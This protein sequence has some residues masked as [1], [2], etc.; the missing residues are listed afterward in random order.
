MLKAQPSHPHHEVV[1]DAFKLRVTALSHLWLSPS[2]P[3]SLCSYLLLFYSFIMAPLAPAVGDTITNGLEAY[4]IL[5]KLRSA[6]EST[7]Y[8][9]VC[10]S[11]R[12]RNRQLALK[13]VLIPSS[14]STSAKRHLMST[15]SL[16]QALH[17]P[18]IVS[19][20]SAFCT[21][22][23]TFHVLEL[24]SLGNLSQF[25]G[26]RSL[27]VLS[28]SELRGVIKSLADALTYLR[29]ALIIH[30]DINPSN[31]LL[32]SDYGVKLS[33]FK[34]SIRLSSRD[35]TA[36]SSLCVTSNYT[37]PELASGESYGFSVDIW[38]L[39]C[40]MVYCVSGQ[41]PFDVI[42]AR[43]L[44]K[45]V[46][47]PTCDLPKHLSSDLKELISS[48]LQVIPEKRI[49][50]PDI[51]SHP[52]LANNMPVVSLRPCANS[53]TRSQKSFDDLSHPP[54][55]RHQAFNSPPFQTNQAIRSTARHVSDQN[56]HITHNRTKIILGDI[57]N[58]DLRNMLGNKKASS[59]I[60]PSA[61]PTRRIVSDPIPR[62]LITS[63]G[64][65]AL[66]MYSETPV[67]PSSVL[68]MNDDTTSAPKICQDSGSLCSATPSTPS[69]DAETRSSELTRIP[70]GGRILED[71]QEQGDSPHSGVLDDEQISA[72]LL[73][74]PVGTVRPT[75]L[76]TS[77][78]GCQTHKTPYGQVTILSSRSLLVDFRESERRKG[79]KGGEVLVVEPD[80]SKISIY[81]APHL[82]SPCCLL[83]PIQTY[84]LQTLPP[85]YWRQYNDAAR[86]V[87]QIKQR[88]PKLVVYLVAAKCTLM[89]NT[90][91]ADIE[92]L[93]NGSSSSPNRDR[94]ANDPSLRIRFS[95]QSQSIEF[96]RH[97]SSARGEEWTKKVL[98]SASEPPYVS[99]KDWKGLE[100]MEKDAMHDLT[101]FVRTC[102][103]VEV[104][105][106]TTSS[107]STNNAPST[108]EDTKFSVPFTVEKPGRHQQTFNSS[109][110]VP[111]IAS[112]FP[113]FFNFAPRPSKLSAATIA[114]STPLVKTSVPVPVAPQELLSQGPEIS[115]SRVPSNIN[116]AWRDDDLDLTVG[117]RGMQTRFMPSVGWCIRYAS[118]VS[119]GGR[120][121]MMFLDGVALDIDVDE[122][123]VEFKSQ[124][125]ETTVYNIRDCGSKRKIGERMKVFEEFV[126]LFD[127]SHE[128]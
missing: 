18:N 46:T 83:E 50:L 54:R 72:S 19:M 125:G 85:V 13:K 90:P 56:Q 108:A 74:L 93:L 29:K 103:V 60:P 20:L 128:E 75:P 80:G 91:L 9:V 25:L 62:R 31:I 39:G 112:S 114:L 73:K 65:K 38:S 17:H 97:I 69:L 118:R 28:E 37:A 87:D 104:L 70:H 12:L 119:Q 105:I 53:N 66:N 117:G 45:G 127:D 88:T 100:Q 59:K 5:E 47:Q 33:N 40:V 124:A 109:T 111:T 14:S 61:R 43:R 16:H 115:A 101:R 110:S 4:E 2:S 32:T 35:S 77:A 22:Q 36:S 52:F 48:T 58:L 107:S 57:G 81:S 41:A 76:N 1:T 122:D 10:K 113:S 78:M 86:L 120:Y 3:L 49:Y 26:S 102:D 126:S 63:R 55:D 84:S 68:Q 89:A 34:Q 7:L 67:R 82:S 96:A 24:C 79:F 15:T 64:I 121:R 95:R 21:T 27:P 6:E 11:G 51:L 116:S 71:K 23:E 123:W 99:T 30:G 42:F 44:P 94:T 8:R 92:L 98:A 106:D